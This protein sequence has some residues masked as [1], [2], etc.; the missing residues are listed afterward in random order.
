MDDELKRK[1]LDI[2]GSGYTRLVCP[3]CGQK[4]DSWLQWGDVSVECENCNEWFDFVK[5]KP[6][7]ESFHKN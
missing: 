4:F 6:K 5:P 1:A 7:E 2:E 3:K